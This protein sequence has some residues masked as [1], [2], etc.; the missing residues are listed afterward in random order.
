MH[1]YASHIILMDV[2]SKRK[3]KPGAYKS[4]GSDR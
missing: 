2:S 4:G 1:I 3:T